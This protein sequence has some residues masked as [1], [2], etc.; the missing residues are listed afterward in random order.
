MIFDF[1]I[2]LLSLPTVTCASR[3]C[4]NVGNRAR[5]PRLAGG[6]GIL[7]ERPPGTGHTLRYRDLCHEQQ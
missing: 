3:V 1:L 4:K 6:V 7:K 2:R 5:L